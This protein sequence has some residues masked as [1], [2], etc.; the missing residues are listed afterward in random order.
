MVL[1]SDIGTLYIDLIREAYNQI[2]LVY[3]SK[4]KTAYILS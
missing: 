4:A 2:S 3:L 1:T